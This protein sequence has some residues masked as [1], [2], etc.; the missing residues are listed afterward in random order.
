[1]PL[2]PRLKELADMGLG[3][4]PIY[5]MPLDDARVMAAQLA[6]LFGPAPDTARSEWFNIEVDGHPVGLHLLA[7]SDPAGIILYFHGGGWVF[8]SAQDSEGLGRSLVEAS[9]CAVVLVDYRLAPEHPF[10]AAIQDADAALRWAHEE[11][12]AAIG[13]HLPIVVAGDSAG[14]NIAAVLA[15]R[16]RGGSTAIAGQLL[17]YPVTDADFETPS[18]MEHGQGALLDRTSMKWFWDCYLPDVSR[19]LDPNAAPLRAADLHGLP[20]AIIITAEYDPLLS[21]ARSFARALAMADVPVVERHFDEMAHGFISLA[22]VV[23]EA[24]EAIGFAG[25]EIRRLIGAA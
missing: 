11:L 6:G 15:L 4:T 8:G 2:H 12:P 22:S 19:R 5:E 20:P 1:M 9:G 24:H 3:G 25:A 23:D 14:G 10:P 13:K 16:A 17:I 21:E 7:P 18:Y